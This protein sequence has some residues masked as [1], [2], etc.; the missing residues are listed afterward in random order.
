VLTVS[1]GL[2]AAIIAVFAFREPTGIRGLDFSLLAWWPYFFVGM[3]AYGFGLRL[4]RAFTQPQDDRL[5]IMGDLS[6]PLYILHRPILE[7]GIPQRV[8]Y[9]LPLPQNL[10]FLFLVSVTLCAIVADVVHVGLE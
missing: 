6:Y 3:F 2:F 5:R 4:P 1:I 8:T 10:V 9:A 7:A